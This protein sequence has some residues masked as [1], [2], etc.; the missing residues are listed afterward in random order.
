[1][2]SSPFLNQIRRFL[3]VQQYSLRTEKTYI[4]WIKRFIYFNKN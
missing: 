1:M 2:P 4:D 3:R